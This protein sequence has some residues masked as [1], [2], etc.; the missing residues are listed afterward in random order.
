MLEEEKRIA[1]MLDTM[2]GGGDLP[3][4]INVQGINVNKKDVQLI[5][6][7]MQARIFGLIK[8]F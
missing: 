3:G 5:K 4:D 1:E 2:V 7:K 6:A 8:P